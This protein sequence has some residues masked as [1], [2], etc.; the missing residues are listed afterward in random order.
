MLNEDERTTRADKPNETIKR[1]NVTHVLL[2]LLWMDGYAVDYS[3]LV[4]LL[5]DG[6]E[7]FG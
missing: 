6:S 5:V 2:V 4:P 3:G 7:G 1:V